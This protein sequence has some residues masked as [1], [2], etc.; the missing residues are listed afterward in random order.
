MQMYFGSTVCVARVDICDSWQMFGWRFVTLTRT[1]LRN[2]SDSSYICAFFPC[3]R[4]FLFAYR[5]A[6][7]NFEILTNEV[8]RKG[9]R[10]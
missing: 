7:T 3:Y 8:S 5:K 9:Q 10:R 1:T 2:T 4:P 6:L